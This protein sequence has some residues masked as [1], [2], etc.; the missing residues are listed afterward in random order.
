[1]TNRVS[2]FGQRL[3]S[4]C[5]SAFVQG[6]F[7]VE[8][9]VMAHEAIHEVHSSG[10]HGVVLKL[11]YEKAYDRVNWDF[12]VEMLTSRGFGNKWIGWILSIL[13][14][15][16]FCVRINDTNGPYFVWGKGLKQGDPLSP[17]LFNLVADVFS[18]ILA[19]AT[20]ANI[21][22]GII[23]YIIPVSLIS[24]KYVDDTILF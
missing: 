1:M 24:L 13:Q 4:P 6:R 12:L 19:K 18:R 10:R 21:I 9:V 20:R 3:L 7:I 17:I 22:R 16:S 14:E 11:D 15:S 2:P 5:Q 8:S 23:P